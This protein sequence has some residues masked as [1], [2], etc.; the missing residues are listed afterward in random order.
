MR[1]CVAPA[2]AMRRV[3]AARPLLSEQF[4]EFR[5]NGYLAMRM[6]QYARLA[7][8]FRQIVEECLGGDLTAHG[9]KKNLINL[10]RPEH[11]RRFPEIMEAVFDRAFLE[12]VFNYYGYVP[13]LASLMIFLTPQNND[14]EK[15]Q[16]WHIDSYD[17]HHLKHITLVED[18]TPENGPFTFLPIPESNAIRKATGKFARGVDFEAKF[19]D[20]LR[21]GIAHVGSAGEG[22][23]VDVSQCLHQGGRTRAGRRILFFVHFATF[24]DYQQVEKNY[25]TGLFFQHEPELVKQFATDPIRRIMLRHG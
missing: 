21:K 17:P 18:V 13:E 4:I 11:L 6:P 14:V 16:L 12:P 23:F 2:R 24:A 9:S 19:A 10:L 20:R 7:P 3:A 1:M 25:H 22:M 5:R 8:V 15:S